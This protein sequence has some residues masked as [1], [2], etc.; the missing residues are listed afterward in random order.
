[1]H[2]YSNMN[3]PGF[4]NTKILKLEKAESAYHIHVQLPKKTHRCPDC[5]TM[6]E[7][8]HDYRSQKIQHLKL[9]ERKTYLFYRKRRYACECGKRFP[10]KNPFVNR[11]QRHTVEWNQALGLRII[12]GKNFKDSAAQYHTSPTT[13]MRRFDQ[14]SSGRLREVETLPKVI[15]IDEYKGD[16]DKGK[17]Q[18]IIGDAKTG[19]PLDILPD[20]SV[21]TVKRY[22]EEK[23]DEVEMVIMDMSYGF[24]SA[25]QKALGKP[26]I[27]DDRFHFCRYIYWALER[28]R[29]RV[30]K[31][32]HPYD[33]KKCKR[34]KHVF[35]K[36]YENLSEKQHWYLER[37]LGMSEELRTAYGLKESFRTWFEG[38]KKEGQANIGKVKTGLYH[39]YR[40]VEKSGMEEFIKAI[41]TLQN[42]QPEILNSFAFGYNNGFIEGL[43]NQTKVIKRNAFGFRRYDRLKHR[44]LLHHQFKSI[45]NSLG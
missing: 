26:I 22:L 12:Q 23:G 37:Y 34:M 45:G 21:S 6:T 5:G 28:V 8:I 16:T 18:V 7:R 15:A 2:M 17:Y 10:E 25:V 24:K 40:Q 27:I 19:R 14:I 33:R 30:Q 43:N 39:F 1:M 36:H 41:Q 13:A 3:L 32:F 11:Y 44:V 4:E 42:W 20:R 31:E 35:Y 29:R 38:A 9:F